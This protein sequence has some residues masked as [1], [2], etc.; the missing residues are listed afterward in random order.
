[1]RHFLS[2]FSNEKKREYFHLWRIFHEFMRYIQNISILLQMNAR[3]QS[4]WANCS[5]VRATTMAAI[6]HTENP[7]SAILMPTKMSWAE[8]FRIVCSVHCAADVCVCLRTKSRNVYVLCLNVC[9]YNSTGCCSSWYETTVKWAKPSNNRQSNRIEEQENKWQK[10][11]CMLACGSLSNCFAWS[12]KR[13]RNAF[14]NE[15]TKR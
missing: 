1:M 11:V 5:L 10:P 13:K 9:A 8:L 14:Q 15:I 2:F 12:A 3:S 4:E 7:I 6:M